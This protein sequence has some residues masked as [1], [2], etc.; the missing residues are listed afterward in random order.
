MERS[1]LNIMVF[2]EESSFMTEKSKTNNQHSR[3]PPTYENL[4]QS[5]QVISSELQMLNQK[6]ISLQ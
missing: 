6:L 4:Q 5:E 1:G 3:K 2:D